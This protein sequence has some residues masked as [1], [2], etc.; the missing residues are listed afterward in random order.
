MFARVRLAQVEH[1]MEIESMN[2]RK[3]SLFLLVTSLRRGSRRDSIVET[4]V[5]PSK[6]RKRQVTMLFERIREA[7]LYS[8]AISDQRL[9]AAKDIHYRGAN[10]LS[11]TDFSPPTKLNYYDVVAV[12]ITRFD[13][14]DENLDGGALGC[15]SS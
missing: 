15:K 2:V 11:L 7:A 10:R 6:T 9:H 1:T 12:A 4:V 5:K 13:L 3:I 14:K 8:Y